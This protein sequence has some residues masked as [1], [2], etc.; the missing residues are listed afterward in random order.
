[1]QTSPFATGHRNMA[2]CWEGG[3]R[4]CQHKAAAASAR[5]LWCTFT[6]YGEELEWVEVFKYLG[7]LLLMDD[8]DGQTIQANLRKACKSWGGTHRVLWSKNAAPHVCGLFYKATV[9][10]VL[11]FGSETWNVT[12]S[13]L[14]LLKGFHVRAEYRMARQNRPTR[15]PGDGKWVYPATKDVLEEVGLHTVEEYVRV[16][17]NTIAQWIATQPTA[18]ACVGAERKRG[19]SARLQWWR[20]KRMELDD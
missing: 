6:A 20:K 3:E 4:F 8:E 10:A 15:R 19:T 12:P 2:L 17:C 7:R 14:C 18:Q 16:Q 1:M 9:Q 5:A 13:S 11:L